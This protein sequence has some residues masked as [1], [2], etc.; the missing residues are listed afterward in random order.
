MRFKAHKFYCNACKRYSNQQ[1][2]GIAKHQRATERF[3]AQAFF[4]HTQGISQKTVANN[5]RVGI[6]T[7][8]RWYQKRYRLE[9]GESSNSPC[10]SI[11]GIDEHFF[12]HKQGFATTFCNLKTHKIYDVVK[13]KSEKSLSGYL[14]ELKGKEQVKV[15]CMDLS[16][17]YRSIV[18]KYFPNA[19]I[20]ADRFHVIRLMQHQFIMTYRTLAPDIKHNTGIM[21]VLR[22]HP[23]NLTVKQINRQQRFFGDNPAIKILYEMR[24]KLHRLLMNKTCHAKRCKRLIPKL[25][26]NS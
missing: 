4:Q 9:R 21:A 15:V 10:P 7:V 2:P 22:K 20:V 23:N 6:T 3:K 26:K 24:I 17:T 18:S 11:L 12:S 25:L 8:E 16:T 1:F 5:L 13:G 14:N 19:L